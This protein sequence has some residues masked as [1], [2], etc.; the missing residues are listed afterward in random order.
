LQLRPVSV[1]EVEAVKG[2]WYG[3]RNATVILLSPAA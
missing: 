3:Y 2:N 1:G